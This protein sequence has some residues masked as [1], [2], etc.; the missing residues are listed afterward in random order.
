MTRKKKEEKE[1]QKIPMYDF[2]G[3]K[4]VEIETKR[5]RSFVGHPYKVLDDESM[6]L[7]T[8]SIRKNG[9]ITPLIVMP[10]REGNYQ[11]I[12]GHRRKYCADVL[13][14]EKV[15][16]II[17]TMPDE[18]S[19]ISMVDTNLQRQSITYSEKAYAYKMKNEAMK[20]KTGKRRKTADGKLDHFRGE[21]KRTVEIISDQCGD[22]PRQITRYIRLTYLIPE[23]MEKLD[24]GELSFNPAV[25]LAFLSE[26]EQR[27]VLD[28]MDFAQA[29]PS[30]SQTHRI[31]DMSRMGTISEESVKEILIEPKK[32]EVG[33]ITFSKDQLRKYFPG[34]Y[35]PEQIKIEILEILDQIFK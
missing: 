33:Q 19:I 15:P 11:I 25:D 26:E 9:I 2:Q 27:W 31:R 34:D 35:S 8:D 22:S 6:R 21:S 12:S 20:R 29:A 1:P 32:K 28:A 10:T 24:I 16:V 18:D 13:G 7:L 3:E 17:R 4:V 5:L 14:L 23:L 30:L